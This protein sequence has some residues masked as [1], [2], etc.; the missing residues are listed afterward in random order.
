VAAFGPP[1]CLVTDL[2]G[3]FIAGVF[4]RSVDRLGT[5][6]RYAAADN[7]RATARLE[8]FWKSLKQIAQIRLIP[9][10][11]STGLIRVSPTARRY[12]PSSVLIPDHCF[13][14]LVAGNASPLPRLHCESDSCRRAAAT[15]PS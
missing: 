7:I 14:C 10:P 5:R 3:D 6:R 4:K 9:P 11:R 1:K 13:L 15:S 2:G 12:K 8:R